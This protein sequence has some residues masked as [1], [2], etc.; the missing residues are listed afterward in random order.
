MKENISFSKLDEKECESC[1]GY[2]NH[3]CKADLLIEGNLK[4]VDSIEGQLSKVR[5][6]ICGV[7]DDW[8]KHIKRANK[9][10]EE[11]RKDADTYPPENV[12]YV[13]ADLQ[14]VIILPR[15]PGLKTAVFT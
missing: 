2:I 8:V 13:S 9:S 4:S 12:F 6:G 3:E 14:K 5:P 10:R 11:Y 7:C 15:L 1:E